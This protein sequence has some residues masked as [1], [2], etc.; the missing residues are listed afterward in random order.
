MRAQVIQDDDVARAQRRAKDVLRV[1][2]HNSSK[3]ASGWWCTRRRTCA[4]AV[5]S[6]RGR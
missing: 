5:A 4:W 6:K 1:R 3:V 2:V